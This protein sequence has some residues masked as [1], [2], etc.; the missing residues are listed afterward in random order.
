M[1][2]PAGDPRKAVHNGSRVL[3]CGAARHYWLCDPRLSVRYFINRLFAGGSYYDIFPL[4]GPVSANFDT[5]L[6]RK[7][8]LFVAYYATGAG[9]RHAVLPP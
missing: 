1:L 8:R 5:L 7:Y 9:D 2:H 6:F 4:R 3:M